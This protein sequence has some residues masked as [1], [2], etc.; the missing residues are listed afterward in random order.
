MGCIIDNYH[1]FYQV[2]NFNIASKYN[3]ATIKLYSSSATA[4]RCPNITYA[5]QLEFMSNIGV[6]F[7]VYDM[8]YLF[9]VLLYPLVR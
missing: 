3:E 9:L 7:Q 4:T 6:R 2:S 5:E 1:H 8:F